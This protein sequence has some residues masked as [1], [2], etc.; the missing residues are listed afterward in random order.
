[1]VRRLRLLLEREL[2]PLGQSA[3]VLELAP[4]SL[5]VSAGRAVFLARSLHSAPSS[6]RHSS[7]ASVELVIAVITARP[8]ISH[9]A[10]PD[11]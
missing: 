10:L 5:G 9:S 3:R 7:P 1:M 8:T 6:F 2:G 4:P 11:P